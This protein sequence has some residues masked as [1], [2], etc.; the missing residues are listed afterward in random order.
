MNKARENLPF[1]AHW[2]NVTEIA[3][4]KYSDRKFSKTKKN[5]DG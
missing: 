5:C 2:E 4:N 1:W 3:K